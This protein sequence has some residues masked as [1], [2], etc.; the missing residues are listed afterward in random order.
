MNEQISR[1]IDLKEL[2]QITILEDL[3]KKVVE[4][5][6]AKGIMNKSN[7]KYQL[8]K[9]IEECGEILQALLAYDQYAHSDSIYDDPDRESK[10]N[11]LESDL[12]S[13]YGDAIVTLIIGMALSGMSLT[14][15]LSSAYNK[16]SKRSGK[17]INGQF[18]KDAA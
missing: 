4:W 3:E 12:R 14:E 17:M 8:S 10:L 11:E 18:V 2:W 5:A 6:N 16:I 7:S 9:T 15:C 13:E 1:G